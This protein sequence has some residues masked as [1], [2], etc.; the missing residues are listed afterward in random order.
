MQSLASLGD[1][2]ELYNLYR[3]SLEP[4]ISKIAT[5]R[6]TRILDTK[7]DKANLPEVV[8]DTCKHLT[9]TQ[10]SDLLNLLLQHEELF[11]GTALGDWQGGEE[12]NFELRPDAR[13]YHGLQ[14]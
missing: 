5:K 9:E 4:S 10:R 13:P 14:K 3:E 2:H 12:V 8:E 6:V 1:K 7:Y 11:D